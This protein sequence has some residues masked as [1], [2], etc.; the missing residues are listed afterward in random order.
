MCQKKA[1]LN[2]SLTVRVYPLLRYAFYF[3]FF[4]NLNKIKQT[5]VQITEFSF[6]VDLDFFIKNKHFKL[7]LKTNIVI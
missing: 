1:I 3:L 7:N 6:S 2:Q 5:S 4:F